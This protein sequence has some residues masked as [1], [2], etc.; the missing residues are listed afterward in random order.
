MKKIIAFILLTILQMQNIY[1][2][3]PDTIMESR[4][5]TQQ[6][7]REYHFNCGQLVIPTVMIGTGVLG[8]TSDWVESKNHTLKDHLV[9]DWQHH[10][11]KVD[12]Y[13][14]YLPV[15]SVYALNL[16]GIK[17]EHSLREYTVIAVTSLVLSSA[18]TEILKRSVYEQRPDE[19]DNR[20]FPSGHTA[21]AFMGAELLRHEYRNVSPWIGVA[22]YAVATGTGFLRIYNNRHWLTDVIAGAGI[23]ILSAKAS[24]WLF[25]YI[26]R[27]LLKNKKPKSSAHFLTNY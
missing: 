15:A 4:E 26:G 19:T 23:G 27:K 21:V 16:C 10:K 13:T 7:D 3:V 11:I 6:P 24:Y 20:S 2:Q 25:P 12:G 9:G 14:Q 1:G 5:T 22:G 8:L 17:G 18:T